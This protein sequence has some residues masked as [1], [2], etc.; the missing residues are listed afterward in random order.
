MLTVFD[1]KNNKW[2]DAYNP[3]RGMTLPR[4]VAMLEA[5]ERGDFADLQWFYHY[6][7]RSDAMIHAVVQRRRATL[8][9][10]DWDIREASEGD[11]GLATEQA[12]VLREA[13]ERI[14]NF[15]D[16]VSFLFSGVFRGFAHLEKHFAPSGLVTRLEPVEQWFWIRDG[17]FGA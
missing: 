13:Y 11:A 10:S 1:A 5:G 7:E 16:A 6:M 2:R 9:A 8:L 4:L 12:A 3:L 14:E 17:L 15:R